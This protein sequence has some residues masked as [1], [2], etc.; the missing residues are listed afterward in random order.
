MRLYR[1][2]GA[3]TDVVRGLSF[4]CDSDCLIE[5][6]KRDYGFSKCLP[7][8]LIVDNDLV[9]EESMTIRPTG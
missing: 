7:A 9:D 1:V 5:V 2:V 4:G 8:G 6:V 3:S